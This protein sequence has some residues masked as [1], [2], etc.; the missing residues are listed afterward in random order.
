[1]IM[2]WIWIHV[3]DDLPEI[4]PPKK[5]RNIVPM[6]DPVLVC[7]RDGRFSIERMFG[8]KKWSGGYYEIGDFVEFWMK[9][10]KPY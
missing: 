3:N 2:P 4:K 5:G 1:M 8:E 6:S 7:T 9:L 10:E